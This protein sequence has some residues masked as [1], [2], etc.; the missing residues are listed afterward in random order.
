MGATDLEDLKKLNRADGPSLW[1]E[2]LGRVMEKKRSHEDRRVK[3]DETA[4]ISEW[5]NK[6]QEE[7]TQDEIDKLSS[8][9]TAISNSAKQLSTTA[10]DLLSKNKKYSWPIVRRSPYSQKMEL[11]VPLLRPQGSVEDLSRVLGDLNASTRRS[12]SPLYS[13]GL[14]NTHLN[15]LSGDLESLVK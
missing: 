6:E 10:D 8:R 2:S 1:R 9:M 14:E 11:E 3:V 15:E 13:L 12:T 7:M 5:D 4:W